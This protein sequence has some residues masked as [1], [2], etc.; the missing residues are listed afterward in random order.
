M[1]IDKTKRQTKRQTKTSRQ[2]KIDKDRKTNEQTETDSEIHA[3]RL[4]ATDIDRLTDRQMHR[5]KHRQKLIGV[6]ALGA[7]NLVFSHGTMTNYYISDHQL[8]ESTCDAILRKAYGSFVSAKAS[9]GDNVVMVQNK[10][11]V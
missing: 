7:K 2:T 4:T 11:D 1:Q 6:L 9:G 3:W 5:L 10:Q 8:G